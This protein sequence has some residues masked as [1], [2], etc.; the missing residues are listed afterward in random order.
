MPRSVYADRFRALF[1]GLAGTTSAMT[2]TGCDAIQADDFE[3]DACKGGWLEGVTPAVAVD[4]LELRSDNG[5]PRVPEL[6]PPYN[7]S[8]QRG[9]P[10][11]TATDKDKCTRALASLRGTSS[12]SMFGRQEYVAFSRG[13]EVG[14]ITSLKGLRTFL[15]PF[16]NPKDGMLLIHVFTRHRP[17]CG[18]ANVRAS[19]DA[20]EFYTASGGTCGKGTHLDDNVVRIARDG[21][22]TI[23]DTEVEKRGNPNCQVGRRP[24]GYVAAPSS[25]SEADHLATSAELEAVS[26]LAFRRLARELRAHGA[27]ADLIA[28]AR[29][30]AKDEVR[31]ARSTRRLARRYGG[32]VK[33]SK[34]G[35]LGVRSL[36]AIAEENAREGCVRETFGALVAT[37]QAA[38]ALDPVVREEMEIIARDE[39]EH[40]AL[41]WDVADWL[42]D[43]LDD[44]ARAR[45]RRARTEATLDL[46]ASLDQAFASPLLGL[47]APAEATALLF[48][49][50]AALS[51]ELAAPC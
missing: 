11:A 5:E 42:D 10:C 47:P 51:H 2:V 43:A 50:Q 18:G 45:V 15:A 39:T 3:T 31:H 49:M 12:D 4:H 44:D 48:R 13:D 32:A 24:E 46:A 34:V 26:V 25:C 28:R 19:G 22:L 35:D 20:F 38:R 30:A 33:S 7:I 40:A 21:T 1:L 41:A 27:P 17:H 37:V 6:W 29:S 23:V 16:D 8:E 36:D 14:A 9:V